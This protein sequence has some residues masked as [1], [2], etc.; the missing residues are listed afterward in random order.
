MKKITITYLYDADKEAL[1]KDVQ[2]VWEPNRDDPWL[3]MQ[4]ANGDI[5]KIKEEVI[6]S[7]R[8]STQ[9]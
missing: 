4:F 3:K 7:Y 8:I 1:H 9:E 5:L 6:E 2:A